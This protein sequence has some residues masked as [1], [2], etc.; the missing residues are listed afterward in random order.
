MD[1]ICKELVAI[2]AS[3]AGHC[4]PC[5]LLHLA[6]ARQ[7]G[8]PEGDIREAIRWASAISD[9]GDR[10]MLEFVE[11]EMPGVGESKKGGCGCI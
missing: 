9:N 11:T 6:I 10:Q 4:Q 1:E 5:F 7:V 2:S 3:V 8:V